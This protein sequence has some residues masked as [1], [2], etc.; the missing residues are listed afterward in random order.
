MELCGKRARSPRKRPSPAPCLE[1]QRGRSASKYRPTTPDCYRQC[2]ASTP[3]K[4][5]AVLTEVSVE[6][7]KKQEEDDPDAWVSLSTALSYAGNGAV[8]GL[9]S[10][11]E[12]YPLDTVKKR[13]QM[14]RVPHCQPFG[15]LFELGLL[16]RRT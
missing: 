6:S 9:L 2:A 14:H 13:V 5:F 12:V 10:K 4:V 16:R 3:W 7:R 1:L 11:L 8:V 15:V